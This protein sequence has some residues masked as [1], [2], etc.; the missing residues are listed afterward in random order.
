MLILGSCDCGYDTIRYPIILPCYDHYDTTIRR[1]NPTFLYVSTT[2][3]YHP[4]RN[5]NRKHPPSHPLSAD[6]PAASPSPLR[7]RPRLLLLLPPVLLLLPHLITRRTSSP[8]PYRLN[9]SSPPLLTDT[10]SPP[11]LSST[12]RLGN[13]K[14]FGGPSRRGKSRS[15]WL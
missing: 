2:Q 14:K 9:V 10:H 7:S 3:T 15:G 6:R 8:S 13:K 5:R 12:R 11:R 1:S 4:H